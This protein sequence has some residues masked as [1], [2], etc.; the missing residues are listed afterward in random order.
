MSTEASVQEREGQKSAPYEF[1]ILAV[2]V[3]SIINLV[4][5]FVV[6][7]ES[8][9]WWLI[10]YVDSRGRALSRSGAVRWMMAGALVLNPILAR[11]LVAG[12]P[13]E[14]LGGV[15]CAAAVLAA[16]RDR[17]TMA[18][19]LLGLAIATKMWAVLVIGPVLLALPAGR[20]RA[21]MWAAA[22][23]GL[24]MLPLLLSAPVQT[25]TAAG[26]QTG[27]VFGPRQLFWLLGSGHDPGRVPPGW[28]THL[29][30][31]LITATVLPV[32]LVAWRFRGLA[33]R[34]HA[35]GALAVLML[36][37][38][39]LDP[40]NIAYYAVPLLIALASWECLCCGRPPVATAVVTAMTWVSCAWL[41]SRAGG[42]VEFLI[43]MAWVL[44]FGVW[45]ARETF[46]PR[47]KDERPTHLSIGQRVAGSPGHVLG[48]PP[49]GAHEAAGP[50]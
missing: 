37:R 46:L 45:L 21:L 50:S 48:V 43:Y 15:L 3:H 28:L 47:T 40:W 6:P 20:L 32:S 33:Q 30:H 27:T 25:Y 8:Q 35:L 31:P 22:V 10:M 2:S 12:H 17:A 29:T 34:E 4:L 18:G 44:P 1:F 11:A 19:V 13:E 9:S 36:L 14:I 5:A 7:F 23:S 39:V 16:A 24:V 38:C 26:G 42:D 41:P 49:A